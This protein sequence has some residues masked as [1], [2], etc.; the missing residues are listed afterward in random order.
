MMRVLVTGGNGKTGRRVAERLRALGHDPVVADR[1]GGGP[2]HVRFDW[3]DESTHAAAADGVEAAYLL[4]PAGIFEL[5]PAMRPFMERLIEGRAGPLVLLSAASLPEGG[6]M[7]GA[8]HAWLEGN[9][10]RWTALRPSW[11]MQ[12]FSEQQHRATI[13]GEDAVYSAADDG[14]VGWISADNIAAVAARALTELD[15]PNGELVMTGPETLSYDDVA[16]RIG[17][18]AGRPIA[19][20][21]LSGAELAVRFEAAGMPPDYAHTLAGMDGAIAAGEGDFTTDT[22]ARVT[23]APAT[24]F[25]DFAAR[26]VVAW[27]RN[28]APGESS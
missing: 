26:N 18:A 3:T 16:A 13:A 12:N 8:V 4:A 22:V 10:P 21:R 2:D 11:F 6:P 1:S 5:V 19:H 14:R 7:M 24:A 20:R 9:A 25:H 23:G 27:A 28:R 17:R 15:W